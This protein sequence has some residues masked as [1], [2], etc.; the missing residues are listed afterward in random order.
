MTKIRKKIRYRW[1]HFKYWL[2]RKWFPDNEL[3]FLVVPGSMDL[4]LTEL[5]T[6]ETFSKPNYEFFGDEL[7][8]DMLINRM[9]DRLKLHMEYSVEINEEEEKV[10][11]RGR[12]TIV[13]MD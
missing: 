7:V 2:I 10:R 8:K 3:H 6:E 4:K 1:R 12:I 11:C 13:R 9:K 5:S